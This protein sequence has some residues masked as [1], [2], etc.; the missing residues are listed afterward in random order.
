M[1]TLIYLPFFPSTIN[2]NSMF[3]VTLRTCRSQKKYFEKIEDETEPP[4]KKTKKDKKNK[5]AKDANEKTEK[6]NKKDKTEP[7][8]KPPSKR[9]K[10]SPKEWFTSQV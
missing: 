10:K 6:K 3:E 7:N 8:E 4:P 9:A 5:D 1:V 2:F